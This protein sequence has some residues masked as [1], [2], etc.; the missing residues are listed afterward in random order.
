MVSTPPSQGSSSQYEV[1]N[2]Q[3]EVESLVIEAKPESDIDLE[4]LYTRDIEFRQETIYFLVVDRFYDGDPDNSEGPNPELY[5][6]E[7]KDWGKYWG[8]DLQGI[9]ELGSHRNLAHPS[10]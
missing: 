1:T 6:P 2:P 7:R 3:A 5:D 8:G 10:V 4:F 9:I